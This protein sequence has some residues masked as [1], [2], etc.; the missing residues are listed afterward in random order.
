MASSGYSKVTVS[1]QGKVAAR[2]KA[3]ILFL[4]IPKGQVFDPASEVE[5]D[6][7]WIP[8]SQITRITEGFSLI[9]GT[10]DTLLISEW[11]AIQKGIM[12]KDAGETS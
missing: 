8:L 1:V 6:R 11:I 10:L 7:H 9:N 5:Y 3:A 12:S 2:S 4:I